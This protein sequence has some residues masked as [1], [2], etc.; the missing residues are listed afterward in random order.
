MIQRSRERVKV[1]EFLSEQWFPQSQDEL[2]AFF[3]NASNLEAITP[4]WLK[5]RTKAQAPVV[6]RQGAIIDY[7]LRIH[8]VPLRWRTEIKVWEPPRRFVDEKIRGPY[9]LCGSTLLRI[10][11]SLGR[12]LSASLPFGHRRCGSDS[13]KSETRTNDQLTIIR[14][15]ALRV[16][17]SVALRLFSSCGLIAGP[18]T[19]PLSLTPFRRLFRINE[20][21]P[22]GLSC[23][24]WF[25]H[26]LST[27]VGNAFP[28]CL[29]SRRVRASSI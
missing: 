6:M 17:T 14:R 11:C 4:P 16:A 13:A 1:R 12:T 20:R 8:G 7:K 3:S 27:P 28:L 9:R 18:A 15:S 29:C 23:G 22:R 24:A 19:T 2:F 5:F 26:F 21:L 25:A 10:A